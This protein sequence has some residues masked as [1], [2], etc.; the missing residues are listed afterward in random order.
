MRG[1]DALDRGELKQPAGC[2]REFLAV[3]LGECSHRCCSLAL[4]NTVNLSQIGVLGAN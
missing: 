1:R 2:V 4:S 3:T